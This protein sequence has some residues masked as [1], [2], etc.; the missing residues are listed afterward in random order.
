MNPKH[1]RFFL[2]LGFCLAC[3][4]CGSYKPSPVGA[5]IFQGQHPDMEKYATFTPASS[6]TSYKIS[7]ACGGS[8][9]LF[10]GND[11]G[12]EAMAYVVFDTTSFTGSIV[13]A[14]LS[15]QLLPYPIK[16]ASSAELQILPTGSSWDEAT[17]AWDDRIAPAAETPLFTVQASLSDSS[18]VIDLDVPVDLAKSFVNADTNVERTGILIRSGA[19]SGFFKLYGRESSASPALIPH[20][21]LITESDTL[22]VMPSKDTF[23]S[24]SDLPGLPDRFWVR[25]GI[26]E[27]ILMRFN[28]GAIPPEATINRAMLV[29]R[30]D[31]ESSFPDQASVF[32]LSAVPLADSVW[33]LPGVALD[34]TWTA[35]ASVSGDSAALVLTTLVQKWT[36]RTEPNCGL[37]LRGVLETTDPAGR[38]FFSASADSAGIPRLKVFYSVPPSGRY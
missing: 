24:F 19:L 8:P 5:E 27:R 22:T 12:V 28:L 38:A 14:T 33:V 29:L 35:S 32:Y 37:M 17:M 6:D 18:T 26:A 20:L 23:V 4:R 30:A 1:N 36:S 13:K 9:F 34:S 16:P 15:F 31:P 10:A 21:T 11:Q 2:F 7:R 3:V 25:D